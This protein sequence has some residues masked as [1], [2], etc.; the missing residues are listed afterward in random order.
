[1]LTN[2]AILYRVSYSFLSKFQNDLSENISL[3]KNLGV[4]DWFK[5]I[6]A[7]FKQI[8]FNSAWTEYGSMI[9]LKSK[10]R[11]LAS[12]FLLLV[13]FCFQYFIYMSSFS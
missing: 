2:N 13:L 4:G 8:L 12:D 10:P 3:P 6:A 11:K 5:K 7:L 9:Q 1:M